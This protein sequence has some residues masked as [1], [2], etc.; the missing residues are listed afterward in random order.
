ML[1]EYKNVF[2]L[3]DDIGTC[4][5]I[6]VE[7]NITDKTPFLIK[8]YHAKSDEEIMLLQYFEGRFFSL[9]QPSNVEEL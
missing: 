6:E 2:S 1:Y 4:P 8:P 9:F 5:N 7:I 3:R